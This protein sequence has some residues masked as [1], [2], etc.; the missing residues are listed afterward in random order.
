VP[1][2]LGSSF[3]W[4]GVFIAALF[5]A[6]SVAVLV[7]GLGESP[8]AASGVTLIVALL[9]YGFGWSSRCMLLGRM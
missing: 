5:A 1:D 4:L 3:Y 7:T 9:S 6:G 8:L 2:L